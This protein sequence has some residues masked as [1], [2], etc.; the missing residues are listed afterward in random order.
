MFMIVLHHFFH[1]HEYIISNMEQRYYSIA[2]H[3]SGRGSTIY[4]FTNTAPHLDTTVYHTIYY[5]CTHNWVALYTTYGGDLY[6]PE[7]FTSH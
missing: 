3:G 7:T 6:W 5:Y 2:K 1:V 4:S